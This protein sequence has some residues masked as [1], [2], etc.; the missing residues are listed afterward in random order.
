M[1]ANFSTAG[2]ADPDG[3]AGA[4]F[5]PKGKVRFDVDF[6]R[7]FINYVPRPLLLNI[8]RL[9]TNLGSDWR[10]DK[11]TIFHIDYY[12]QRYSDTNFGQGGDIQVTRNLVRR[13]RFELEAGY[14]YHAFGFTKDIS[15]GF[16]SPAF[17]QEHLALGN[18]SGKIT[19]RLGWSFRGAIGRQQ[20]EGQETALE[21]F[22]KDGSAQAGGDYT[23]SSFLKLSFGYV[24]S[25]SSNVQ[26]ANTVSTGYH[27]KLGYLTLEYKF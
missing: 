27:A 7:S 24:Y 3:S 5:F 13:E 20:S 15:S 25:A 14:R 26:I 19:S 12:Q 6:S 8:S 9:E 17:Y 2:H 21:P 18:V 23:I 10:V 11:R 4:T 22:H 1:G 16:W